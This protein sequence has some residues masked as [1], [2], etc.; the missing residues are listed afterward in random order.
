V[1]VEA[2][3]GAVSWCG[4]RGGRGHHGLLLL[5]GDDLDGHLVRVRGWG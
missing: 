1:G 2:G 3:W 4:R 5:A